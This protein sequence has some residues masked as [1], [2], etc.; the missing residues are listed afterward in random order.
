MARYLVRSSVYLPVG[1]QSG[2]PARI[3]KPGEEVEFAG[4]PTSDALQPIDT[5]ARQAKAVAPA[6]PALHQPHLKIIGR[7]RALGAE[8][9]SVEHARE[10]REAF[11]KQHQPPPEGS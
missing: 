9:S 7:A 3:F 4:I 6:M 1:T 5:E 2:A 8:P 11:R 10:L